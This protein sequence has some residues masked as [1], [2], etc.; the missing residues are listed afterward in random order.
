MG[1]TRRR[2]LSFSG[3]RALVLLGLLLAPF[4]AVAHPGP[5]GHRHGAAPPAVR[6]RRRVRRGVRRRTF[7]RVTAG[8]RILVVPTAVVVGD[9]LLVDDK[10]VVVKEVTSTT[11]VVEDSSGESKTIEAVKEDTPENAGELEG[12]E[13]EEE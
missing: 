10:P 13:V 7:W 11:V 2:F 3:T 12:S 4:G 1:I 5:R 8:R 6:G 9:E